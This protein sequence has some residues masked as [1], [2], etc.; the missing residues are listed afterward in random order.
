MR[1]FKHF[2]NYAIAL[3]VCHITPSVTSI[4]SKL[5]RVFSYTS[6]ENADLMVTPIYAVVFYISLSLLSFTP[7]CSEMG[8]PLR[9]TGPPLNSLAVIQGGEAFL[10]FLVN[11]TSRY[12]MPAH[13]FYFCF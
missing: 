4:A 10:P 2:R 5:F 12:S 6:R 8:P 3:E 11:P 9:S 7:F 13:S 1:W